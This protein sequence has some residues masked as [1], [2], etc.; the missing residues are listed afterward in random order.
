MNTARDIGV[1]VTP[2][3]GSC[4]DPHCPFHGTLPVRGQLLHGRV[5]LT[6]MDRSLVLKR[7]HLRYVPKYER[8][9]KRTSR[10]TA[11]FPPCLDAEPGDNVAIM[12]CRPI[13]KSKHFVV[14]ETQ[15][16]SPDIL[17]EDYTEAEDLAIETPEAPA[18]EDEA[19]AEEAVADEDTDE[20]PTEAD[21]ADEE[22]A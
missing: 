11:H 15:R 10:Y 5:V 1:D 13:S 22:G 21:E 18:E 14:V 4:D 7:E 12:E 8:Y 19:E 16:G 17:I 6:R 9:E 3:T 20:E 2:P